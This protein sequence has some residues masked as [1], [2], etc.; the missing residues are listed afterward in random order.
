MKKL[1]KEGEP[2]YF[3]FRHKESGDAQ[4]ALISWIPEGTPVP[5]LSFFHLF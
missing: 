3:F 2:L 1:A 5:F 4:W